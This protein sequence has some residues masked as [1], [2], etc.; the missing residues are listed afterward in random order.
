MGRMVVTRRATALL[1]IVGMMIAPFPALAQDLGLQLD[2]NPVKCMVA[3]QYPQLMSGVLPQVNGTK[4]R[5]YFKSVSSDFYYVEMTYVQGQWSGR[6]PRP[7]VAAS[8]LTYYVE[9]A[10]PGRTPTRSADYNV[11]V[12]ENKCSDDQA[13]AP[14]AAET[15]PVTVFSTAAGAGMPAGFLGIGGVLAGTPL[16]G[17]AGGGLAGFLGSPLGLGLAGALVVGGAVIISTTG[18]DDEPGTSSR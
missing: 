11:V 15:G 7:T 14:I 4:A 8:P 18:G 17:V 16:G 2:H 5:V 1:T 12:V 9:A 3:G 6:L 10:A 13:A